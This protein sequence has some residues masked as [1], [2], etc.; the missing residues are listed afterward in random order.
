MADQEY[1]LFPRRGFCEVAQGFVSG[2]GSS[3]QIFDKISPSVGGKEEYPSEGINRNDIVTK[4][5][6]DDCRTPVRS[7]SDLTHE[8]LL[9]IG[10]RSIAVV[11]LR[12]DFPVGTAFLC[13]DTDEIV[14]TFFGDLDKFKRVS[15]QPVKE[16]S[17]FF[18][19]VV[20]RSGRVKYFKIIVSNN[21]D[22]KLVVA[23]KMISTT[24]SST[25]YII[26]APRVGGGHFFL[27][28][29]DTKVKAQQI[30]RGSQGHKVIAAEQCTKT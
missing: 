15:D 8:Y 23:V 17:E 16:R 30:C 1:R 26:A 9:V 13:D 2:V 10:I 24:D 6:F 29:S 5:I 25:A 12:A 28:F 14:A 22:S 27:I 18:G 3:I 20:F 4:R 7:V 11:L 21:E 19:D